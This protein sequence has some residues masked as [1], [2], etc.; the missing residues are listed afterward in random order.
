MNIDQARARLEKMRKPLVGLGALALCVVALGLAA[1]FFVN[2]D[3]F[4]P[5]LEAKLGQA[6]GRPVVIEKSI[7]FRLLPSPAATVRGVKVKAADGAE[8]PDL[9]ELRKA[10]IVLA[11]HKLIQ[12]RIVFKAIE[13]DGLVVTLE[14]M[15]NGMPSWQ[16]SA[17]K[18]ADDAPQAARQGDGETPRRQEG[19]KPSPGVEIDRL[20]LTNAAFVVRDA[21]TKAESRIDGIGLSVESGSLL[22]PYKFTGQANLLGQ[23]VLLSGGLEEVRVDRASPLN[24]E[25]S[26][27]GPGFKARYAGLLSLLSG[28]YAARGKLIVEAPNLDGLARSLGL[29]KG[30]ADDPVRIESTMTASADTFSMDETRIELAG[31]TGYGKLKLVVGG[32]SRVEARLDMDR[33]DLDRLTPK[34]QT[35]PPPSATPPAVAAKEGAAGAVPEA[36]QKPA[37]QEAAQKPAQLPVN[38]SGLV[39]LKIGELFWNGQSVKDLRVDAALNG[40]ELTVSQISAQLPSGGDAAFFGFVNNAPEGMK[41]EGVLE[42]QTPKLR[43]LLAW[44]G[45]DAKNVAEGRLQPFRLKASV[46]GTSREV[47]LVNL[48]ALLDE[49]RLLGAAILKP[50][51]RPALGL[52]LE[53]NHLDLDSYLAASAPGEA[54]TAQ[55]FADGG[56]SPPSVQAE[57]SSNA[58]KAPALPSLSFLKSFD[59]NLRLSA[60]SLLWRRTQANKL[61][62]DA[63]LVNGDLLLR[64]AGVADIAGSSLSA[65]GGIEGVGQGLPTLKK[66]VVEV[67]SRQ[68]GA[69]AGVLGASRK[70]EALGPFAARAQLDGGV[71]GLDLDAGI[72]A[73]GGETRLN[74]RIGNLILA[75][76][77]FEG[78]VTI[79]HPNAAQLFKQGGNWGPLEAVALAN[80]GQERVELKDMVLKL[81]KGQIDGSAEINLSGERAQLAAKLTGGEID[82]DAY[83]SKKQA[84]AVSSLRHGV[85]AAPGLKDVS[86][87]AVAVS[88]SGQRWSTA[89]FELD[90]LKGL[91]GKVDLSLAALRYSGVRLTKPQTSLE[92]KDGLLAMPKLTATLW[93]GALEAQARLSA[94]KGLAFEGKATLS[95]ADLKNALG[96]TAGLTQAAGK[97][98]AQTRLTGQGGSQAE[99][100][101]KLNGDGGFA[102]KDGVVEGIDLPAIN[103]QLSGL[104]NIAGL[105]GVA[106]SLSAGGKTA[107]SQMSGSFKMANGVAVS[108][109]VKLVADGGQATGTVKADLPQWLQESKLAFKLSGVDN[110]PSIGMRLQGPLDAPRKFFDIEDLQRWAAEKGL[111]K[112]LK[113][114]DLQGLLGGGSSS[115]QE[116][117]SGEQQP[118]EKISKKLRNILK[119]L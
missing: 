119:G 109:D 97:F 53:L 44:F 80:A 92:L 28:G 72:N 105:A 57:K 39:D 101:A 90:A 25:M 111:L 91:D 82:L 87:A 20:Q 102:A 27:P 32:E 55:G 3:A 76:P 48:D 100:V 98:D 51:P 11:L 60:G 50:G 1:P 110:G 52:A 103:R 61:L 69:L 4:R 59:A 65:K 15:A 2:A 85:A 114:K 113:G 58:A 30:L 67:V 93:G 9:V 5:E 117:S 36:S 116:Q 75:K 89:P 64:E 63:S 77:K 12:G 42:A 104:N 118:P 107:F 46:Q 54:P 79:R 43:S 94:G 13:M 26:L 21:R 99:L 31:G 16:P 23:P 108:N 7:D 81:G 88:P 24:I 47:R 95:G 45:W 83:L 78:R 70:I 74:G 40:G 96:E 33:L 62:L 49:S 66:L 84:A 73:Q 14:T 71:D 19:G 68:P 22:G 35:A 41:F 106:A 10:R 37:P 38:L 29:A 18:I 86:L 56:F 17:A 34:G 8:V 115:S 112:G 6:L